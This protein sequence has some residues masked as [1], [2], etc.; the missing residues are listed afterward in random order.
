MK[1]FGGGEDDRP[2]VKKQNRRRTLLAEV[3]RYERGLHRLLRLLHEGRDPG[4]LAREI[5]EPLLQGKDVVPPG[6]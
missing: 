5:V 6:S 4:E 2:T 3:R 1:L